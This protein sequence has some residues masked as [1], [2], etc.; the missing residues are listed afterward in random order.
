MATDRFDIDL[1]S[2]HEDAPVPEGRYSVR[3]TSLSKET[4]RKGADMFVATLQIESDEFPFAEPMKHYIMLPIKDDDAQMRRRRLNGL[5]RFLEAF[6]ITYEA[7]GFHPGDAVGQVA[8][9]LFITQEAVIN[10]ETK[11]ETG[12][13]RNRAVF[14]K[15]KEEED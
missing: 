1:G 4:S 10:P 12:R 11:E 2:A 7:D 5:R 9:E 15:V 3:C 14:P 6:E 8:E 13:V